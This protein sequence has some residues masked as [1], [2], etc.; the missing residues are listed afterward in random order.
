MADEE[1][2]LKPTWDGEFVGGLPSGKVSNTR[3]PLFQ[4][5]CFQKLKIEPP[6]LFQTTSY[7]EV[8]SFAF[9]LSFTLK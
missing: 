3:E 8:V 9:P 2:S 4:A 5:F 7:N 1:E 6:E